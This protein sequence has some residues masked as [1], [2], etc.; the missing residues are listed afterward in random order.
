MTTRV[1][2]THRFQ[3][4]ERARKAMDEFMPLMSDVSVALRIHI[5]ENAS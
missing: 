2:G 1:G 5:S 4:T 3:K